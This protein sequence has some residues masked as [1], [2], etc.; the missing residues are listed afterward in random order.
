M[1][2]VPKAPLPLLR[3]LP[4]L[5]AH[6]HHPLVVVIQLTVLLQ[7]LCATL[8]QWI[9]SP[10]VLRL[11]SVAVMMMIQPTLLNAV[12]TVPS[13]MKFAMMG[14]LHL[15][16]VVTQKISANQNLGATQS[17]P[18]SQQLA[19]LQMGRHVLTLIILYY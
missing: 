12:Q 18:V 10:A 4:P 6:H 5:V 19:V 9:S 2:P 17:S 16:P 1:T 15:R 8:P 14:Q 11:I 13:P 7:M 3:Q